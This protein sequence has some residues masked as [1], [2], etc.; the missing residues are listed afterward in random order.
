MAVDL[1]LDEMDRAQDRRG[2]GSGALGMA[3]LLP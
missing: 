3:A 2:D 1:A